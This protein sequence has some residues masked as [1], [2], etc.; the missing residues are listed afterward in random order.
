MGA[1]SA[2]QLWEAALGELQIQVSKPN[3]K[4]WLERTVGLGYQDN[5]FIVGVPNTFI[6]EYLDKNQR[7]LIEKTLIGL[8]QQETK[9]LFHVNGRHQNSPDSYGTRGKIP[10]APPASLS[11]FNPRY[12]FDSF[13]VGSCN[14]LAHAAALEVAKNPGHSHNPLFIYGGVGLGKTHLL[15][16]IGHVALASHMRVLYVSAEQFTN[17]FINAI[18][19][20]NTE[21]FRN[22][23]RNVDMLLIDDIHFI[24]GKGQTEESFFHTFN[25][26]HNAN[27]QIV[28]TSDRLPKSLP[29]LTERLRSRFEWGLIADI[30]PP[31][32]E[33][34]LAILQAKAERE[35]VDIALDVLEFIAHQVPHNIRELEGSLNR[36]IT[37]ANLVRALLTPELVAEALKDIAGKETKNARV[38]PTL[39]IE[40]VAKSF[41]LTPLDLKS[42]KRD[43][44]TVLA[45]YVAIYLIKEQTNCSLTQIGNYLGKRDHHIVSHAY[46]K[47]TSDMAINSDLRNKI[48]DIQQRLYPQNY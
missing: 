28:V 15:H 27:H 23:Y 45:R 5:Q 26:L 14:R 32:F 40:A 21:E 42:Q 29:L 16:A 31:D 38:T 30:Q 17:E 41:Q 43:K 46:K 1:P 12:T 35:R 7:S 2:Q 3:Y 19:E 33:T 48:L 34:R 9:V 37:Y 36:V 47:I 6:A 24:S 10:L 44:E 4:T 20:R 25:E 8:T 11:R 39:I 22:K 13:T 18:R